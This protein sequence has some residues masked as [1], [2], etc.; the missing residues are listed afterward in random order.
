MVTDADQ[1]S[2]RLDHR[3]SD[4]SQLF[5]RFNFNNL[6]G[7]TTNPDQTVLDP[8]FAIRY[9]DRQRNLV[10]TYTRTISPRLISESSVS[11]LP[12]HSLFSHDRPD[13]PRGQVQ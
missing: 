13:R 11:R 9:I 10:V 3:I 4:R 8:A 5:A 1:F 7:P 12:R 2:V 6:N